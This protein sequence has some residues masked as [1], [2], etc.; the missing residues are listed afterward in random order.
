MPQQSHWFLRLLLR[1]YPRE[2]RERHARDLLELCRDLNPRT[3]LLASARFWGV[4][5]F[6]VCTS[7]VAARRDARQ[8]RSA[9]RIPPLRTSTFRER[10]M[11]T[12]SQDLRYAI[13]TIRTNPGY[14]A[15]IILTL[16]LGIGANSAIFSII[17]SVLLQPLPY[18]NGPDLVRVRQE[19]PASGIENLNL[20]VSELADYRQQNQSF[21]NMV[22]Y[23]TMSFNL[24]GHG[25]PE[26]VQ[27]GV[28][29]WNFF[30]VLGVKPALGRTFSAD[31]DHLTAEPVLMLGHDY[32][33]RRFGGREDIVGMTV[34]MNDRIHTIVGVLEPVPTYPNTNDVWMPW[35]ACPFR[36]GETWQQNRRVRSLTVL[37]R[38]REGVT[39]HRAHEDLERIAQTF[40]SKYPEWNYPVD[41]GVSVTPLKEE[42]TQNAR[43][44][45]LILLGMAGLVLL[46]ACA[47]VANLTLARMSRREQEIALRSALG[48]GRGRLVR[49]LLTESTMLSLV[50]GVL[51]LAVAFGVVDM[52]A[53]FASEFT[54][55]A[56]EVEVDGWV[57]AFTLGIA[58]ATGLVVGI[59]PAFS[60]GRN[61]FTSLREGAT[62]A[63][64]GVP[65]KRV[66]SSLVVAQLAITFVLLIGAGLMARSFVRLS[67]VDPGF[68]PQ[69]IVTM[70]I[71][72]D[73]N[74]YTTPERILGFYEPFLTRV[75]AL[76]Q[77][78]ASGIS[79]HVPL[80]SSMSMDVLIDGQPQDENTP[81]PD[82][83]WEIVSPD[84]F[85][86]LRIPLLLGRTF[87][88][89]EDREASLVTVISRSMAD[90]FFPDTDPLGQ[91]I[92]FDG[93]RWSTVVGVVGDVR[94]NGLDQEFAVQAYL[95][96]LQFPVRGSTAFVRTAANP[97][98][99][100]RTVTDIVHD[101]DPRQPVAFIQT[102]REVRSDSIASPRVTTVLLGLFAG[103]ALVISVAG[104]LGL[105]AYMVSQRT[106]EI[107]I[108]MALGARNDNVLWMIVRQGVTLAVI[109]LGVGVL[110]SLLLGRFLTGMLFEIQPTDPIT[111]VIVSLVLVVVATLAAY[112]PAR[113][114][115]NIDPLLALRSE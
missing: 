17:N 39:V 42:L 15:I 78:L 8:R 82:I 83:N 36:S 101:I 27:T 72:L 90:Q 71:D 43:T 99:V 68:D 92:S 79:M 102:M 4:F 9:S 11:G 66:R 114:V 25:E 56:G 95:S 40:V 20:S 23:H 85:E 65:G 6:D 110:G 2:F 86:A 77:V 57:L 115:T 34:E 10:T 49:Q 29:S 58:V 28:V 103:L 75:N 26:R 112:I 113:R 3:S 18:A 31:E 61:L 52:L 96:S 98:L 5:A 38:L 60:F 59:A 73:W 69:N 105:V 21:D 100:A 55:R 7:G 1:A 47:N 67:R 41:A 106:H 62:H 108:R 44:T 33:K 104:V 64:V 53:A 91:R 81:V 22:E 76:P 48:A 32:W 37:G 74:F 51:G 93:E 107:G 24:L 12:L 19:A 14:A 84:Y 63:T 45:F 111:F 97:T 70:Q 46:I 35:Y 94:Q 54:P 30:D 80:S 50:G 109:G 89:I 87:T 88:N 16:A 13:R